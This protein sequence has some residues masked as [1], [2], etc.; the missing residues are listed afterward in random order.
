MAIKIN[1]PSAEHILN[2]FPAHGEINAHRYGHLNRSLSICPSDDNK[3][4]ADEF[5]KPIVLILFHFALCYP[6]RNV[7]K[8]TA[9]G[10]VF[11]SP[12]QFT[13]PLF[14]F[15]TRRRVPIR[16]VRNQPDRDPYRIL[17]FFQFIRASFARTFGSNSEIFLHTFIYLCG[18]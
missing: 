12:E 3:C 4:I 7:C 18:Q 1:Y 2:S 8:G 15:F 11:I 9:A 17:Q 14:G 5:R 13:E 6:D 16:L 10:G